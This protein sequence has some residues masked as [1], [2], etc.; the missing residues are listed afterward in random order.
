MARK[1]DNAQVLIH[2]VLHGIQSSLQLAE[3]TAQEH[4]DFSISELE[5]TAS[6]DFEMQ[7]SDSVQP[8]T[9]PKPK[10]W[11]ALFSRRPTRSTEQETRDSDRSDKGNLK[12]RMVF[13]PGGKLIQ[14]SGS[15]PTSDTSDDSKSGA[16][17]DL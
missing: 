5:V 10:R 3:D 2:D 15:T 14:Q 6:F 16:D 13:R 9:G 4:Y 12:L 7:D 1:E 8:R 17:T 11:L